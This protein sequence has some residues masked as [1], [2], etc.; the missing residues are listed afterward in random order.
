M[1]VSGPRERYELLADCLTG[2][3]TL[4]SQLPAGHEAVLAR[5]PERN[6][7]SLGQAK[8]VGRHQMPQRWFA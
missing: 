6:V 3:A 2:G 5:N 7:A 8:R 1:Q 4:G